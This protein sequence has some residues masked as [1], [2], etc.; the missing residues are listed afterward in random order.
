MHQTR[1]IREEKRISMRGTENRTSARRLGRRK[2]GQNET[3]YF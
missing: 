1:R 3:V 2:A